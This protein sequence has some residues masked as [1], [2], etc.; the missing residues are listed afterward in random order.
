MG[1]EISSS[2]NDSSG[3]LQHIRVVDLSINILGPIA[4]Q[5]LGDMGADVIKVESPEGDFMRSVG[6]SRNEHMGAFFLNMNRNKRGVVLNLKDDASKAALFRLI[7]TADV[8][9]HNMRPGAA[10][11]LGLDYDSIKKRKPDILYAWAT[12]FRKDSSR[13]ELPAYDDVVQGIS[14]IPD[15]FRRRSGEPEYF[16]MMIADKVCG[17]SLANAIMV[18]LIHRERTGEGQEIHLPMYDTMV[19]FNLIDHLWYGVLAEPERGLGYQRAL[20]PHRKPYAT[21]DGY[22]ALMASTDGHWAKMFEVLERPELAKDPLYAKAVNRV[23]RL[24]ELYEM[25]GV[26]LKNKTTDEWLELFNELQIPSGRINTL[27]DLL[28]DPYFA[29]GNFFIHQQHPSEG[30]MITMAYP[31]SFSKTGACYSKPVPRLGQHTKEILESLDFSA[32]QIA[33]IEGRAVAG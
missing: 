30:A 21:K 24:G 18:G 33:E 27:E 3:A 5:I 8:L 4:T 6:P 25:L 32:D 31:A 26:M 14:G 22:I 11:R 16:P 7:D 29:E 2:A 13:S 10:K 23:P 15:L 9:V 1:H 20:T 28:A 17:Y 12:G 19:A